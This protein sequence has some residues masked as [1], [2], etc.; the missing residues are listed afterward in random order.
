M[1]RMDEAGNQNLTAMKSISQKI[2]IIND[3]ADKT[4]ILARIT[5]YNVCYTKLLRKP[6]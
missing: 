1:I 4:N 2:S 6:L 3:I 5:S